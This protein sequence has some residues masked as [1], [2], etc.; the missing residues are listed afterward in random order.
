[1]VYYVRGPRAAAVDVVHELET[2]ESFPNPTQMPMGGQSVTYPAMGD[3]NTPQNLTLDHNRKM[4]YYEGDAPRDAEEHEAEVGND[5]KEL[6]RG[7]MEAPLSDA[8]RWDQ[9]YGQAPSDYYEGGGSTIR[10][11]NTAP[12]MDPSQDELRQI[13]DQLGAAG[14]MVPIPGT[15]YGYLADTDASN[16]T[17]MIDSRTAEL[18]VGVPADYAQVRV[19]QRQPWVGVDLDG[20]I[21]EEPPP[22]DAYG[23]SEQQLPFGAPMPGAAEAL[24]EL[25]SLGW[26]IS[27][28]T[29]RFG[30]ESLDDETIERWAAEI[31]HHLDQCEIPYSDIWVGRKPRCD[32][33]VDNKAVAFQGDWA[34]IVQQLTLISS[35]RQEPAD[36][37]TIQVEEHEAASDPVF[38]AGE[39]DNDWVDITWGPRHPP[40]VTDRSPGIEEMVHGD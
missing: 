6:D 37:G 4:P 2:H 5:L 21:L 22:S 32:V 27:I 11:G 23:S 34:D 7:R 20:T 10:M 33:F 31:A 40:A 17:I 19:G 18:F 14:R 3:F 29:A 35:E 25:A 12:N 16:M 8:G 15:P 26:R 9:S 30:D 1:M 13:V 36:D 39:S 38:G 24:A 28:Y